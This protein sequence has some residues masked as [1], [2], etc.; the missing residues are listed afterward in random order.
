[1]HLKQLKLSGFK[2]FVDP[3]TIPFCSQ[4]IAVVG[5]NGCGKSNIIDAVRWVMGEGS[6]KN[7][8]GESMADVIFKGSSSRKSIGQASVEMV[9]DNS[10]GRLGG[11]YASYQE[12]AVKRS[13]TLDGDSFYYLNG[14]KCRR[15]DITDIFLG[16]GAQARGYSIIGQDTISRLVEARPEDLRAYLEE[17]AGV[18]KYKDRRRETMTRIGHTRENLARVA[19]IRDELAKQIGKLERQAKAA[20]RYKL[21]KQNERDCKA[22]ILALK[23]QALILEQEKLNSEL[24]KAQQNHGTDQLKITD[25]VKENANLREKLF[26]AEEDFQQEQLRFYQLNTEIARLEEAIQQK[27]R[28]KSQQLQDKQQIEADIAL[29]ILQ[30]NHDVETLNANDKKLIEYQEEVNRLQAEFDKFQIILNDKELKKSNLLGQWQEAQALDNKLKREEEIHKINLKHL[31]DRYEHL[32]LSYLKSKKEQEEIVVDTFA[33]ELKILEAQLEDLIKLKEDNLSD[34][35]HLTEKLTKDRQELT[36]IEQQLRLTEDNVKKLVTE[37]ASLLAALNTALQKESFA[38]EKL[39]QWAKNLRLTE[40]FKVPDKWL[41]SCEMVLGDNLYAIVLDSIKELIPLLSDLKGRDVLFIEKGPLSSSNNNYP[42][43]LDMLEW[44]VPCQ[45]NAL[46]DIFAADNLAEALSWLPNLNKNESIVTPDGYWLGHGFIRVHGEIKDDNLGLLVRKQALTKLKVTLNLEQEKLTTLKNSRDKL[47]ADMAENDRVK[48]L[49]EN[50]LK[51]THEDLRNIE[52]SLNNKSVS[53]QNLLNRRD[54]LIDESKDLEL[55]IED[56]MAE[57]IIAENK[58]QLSADAIKPQEEK[59]NNLNSLKSSIEEEFS[60]ARHNVDA[61]RDALHQALLNSE[62][63]ALVIKQ[64]QEN[65]TRIKCN[66]DNLNERLIKLKALVEKSISAEQD[67]TNLDEKL[68]LHQQLEISLANKKMLVDDLQKNL[69]ENERA[70]KEAGQTS[71]VLQEKIQQ[72]QL[73]VQALSLNAKNIAL[74]LKELDSD[75]NDLIAKMDSNA[76]VPIFEKNLIDIV[77]KISKL[78]DINLIAIDEYKTELERKQSLDAQYQ[79]LIDALAIL[80]TAIAKMDKETKIRLKDTFDRLN[81]AFQKLFPRLFG[82]GRAKLE[83]TCDNLLE[84]GIIVMAE[85]PGKRNSSIHMLSGGEKAMTAVA[86]VF[87]IFQLNPSPFCML[88]EVD[89]PLDEANIRRFCDLVKEMS[90]LVQFLFITHNK[91]TMEMA[92]HLI[93]VTM[94]EPGVSRVVTVDVE[95]LVN[96]TTAELSS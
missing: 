51:L 56:L 43:L 31:K 87:A 69:N 93:G 45:L 28:E 52:T 35:K 54:K 72:Q 4:L 32:S 9:F 77:E 19:D 21:L 59:L 60:S 78:G 68:K 62:K 90:Q 92:D 40:T 24:L 6:A 63:E 91:V 94:R 80:D 20:E 49:A 96:S 2:S 44:I 22:Q 27:N 64:L 48:S 85:P 53:S 36:T 47:Y 46:D 82:G 41:K 3:T 66:I 88:D 79:D 83:L 18:S 37:E 30:L 67:N 71:G 10:L 74:L 57:I 84:A 7:L 15:R 81:E 11:A 23:W 5:P 55:A 1:M 86:L 25:L 50:A 89:A 70:E 39:S 17:A 65:I 73:Q 58:W 33:D 95:A 26:N 61:L 34:V 76:M 75:A 42:R 12:I 38:P 8:R 14:T 13:V 16:T 29:A